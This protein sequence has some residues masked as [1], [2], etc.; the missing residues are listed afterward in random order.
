MLV[1]F[2]G[3]PDAPKQRYEPAYL[4]VGDHARRFVVFDFARVSLTGDHLGR[5]IGAGLRL[6]ALAGRDALQSLPCV[7]PPDLSVRQSLADVALM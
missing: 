5:A 7:N 3:E 1:L 2:D 4:R 6:E